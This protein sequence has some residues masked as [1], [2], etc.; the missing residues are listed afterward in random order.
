LDTNN[1]D[2]PGGPDW[3]LLKQPV[4]V[5]TRT[6][7]RRNRLLSFG[8]LLT[9]VA[10]GFVL[11]WS[12][13]DHKAAARDRPE[14]VSATPAAFPGEWCGG[15]LR[16]DDFRAFP[17][18]RDGEGPVAVDE[19]LKPEPGK[20]QFDCVV[21]D[22]F[23]GVRVTAVLGGPEVAKW[24]AVKGTTPTRLGDGVEGMTDNY[25]AWVD[26]GCPALGGVLTV[27][28]STVKSAGVAA[29]WR[30]TDPDLHDWA[31]DQ[32]SALATLALRAAG[33]VAG[34]AGCGGPPPPA[35]VSVVY[36]KP[37]VTS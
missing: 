34:R 1:E 9:V 26:T 31:R 16:E 18:V 10:C 19:P 3:E 6:V 32:R 5:R 8:V 35:Q 36:P 17:D 22:Y 2:G 13:Q 27:R 15:V 14:F 12:W 30:D 7:V 25:W 20:A 11:R 28:A 4:P 33:E 29:G 21:S 24:K 37:G 23:E